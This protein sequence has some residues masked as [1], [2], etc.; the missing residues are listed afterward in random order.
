[1]KMIGRTRYA[2][3]GLLYLAALIGNAGGSLAQEML[4]N[5]KLFS[6]NLKKIGEL[7]GSAPASELVQEHIFLRNV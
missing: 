6:L 5:D 7:I 4:A 2:S 3:L 1:M